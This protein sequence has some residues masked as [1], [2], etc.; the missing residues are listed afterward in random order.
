MIAIRRILFPTDFSSCADQALDYALRLARQYQAE[1]HVLHAT[2]LHEDDPHHPAHHLPDVAALRARLREL[3]EADMKA[4]VAAHKG[5]DLK[6]KTAQRFGIAAAPTILEYAED[7]RIDLI[8]MGTHGRRGLGRLFLGSVAEEVVRHAS[9][10]VLTVR[11]KDKARKPRPLK[12]ILVPVDYSPHALLALRYAMELAQ[13][14]QARVHLLHVVEETVHPA[15]YATGKTSIFDFV[16]DI[17]RRSMQAMRE[18]VAK[19]KGP[20]TKTA[21]HVA[22][23]RAAGEIVTWCETHPVDLLVIATHGLTGL[24]HLLLGSVTE[25]VVRTAPCPVFTVKPFGKSLLKK[26]GGSARQEK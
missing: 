6:V 26:Q 24:E 4:A 10:P 14:T 7:K 19:A 13:P 8:V 16:P 5:G 18:L 12:H 15:F 25:R 9:C 1:L 20:E 22:E 23:G 21:L 3:A 2:V 11:G 17:R